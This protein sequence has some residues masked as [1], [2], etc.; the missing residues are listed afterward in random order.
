MF[1]RQLMAWAKEFF[2]VGLRQMNVVRRDFNRN[3]GFAVGSS[4]IATS[5]WLRSMARRFP[6]RPDVRRHWQQLGW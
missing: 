1:G 6:R 2:D 3:R 4:F 5:N